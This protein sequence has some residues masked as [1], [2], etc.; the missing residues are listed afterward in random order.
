MLFKQEILD[1]I[2]TGEITLAFRRWRRPT[3]KSGGRLRTAIG[4]LAIER[5]SK[6]EADAIADSEARRAGFPDRATL[7]AELAR[8]EGEVFR[9][10]LRFAGAD[11]RIALRKNDRIGEAELALIVGKLEKM[12]SGRQGKWVLEALRLIENHPARRASD[13]AAMCGMDTP[14]FKRKVR[15]LKELGLTESL[16][17][18]YRLSPRGEHVLSHLSQ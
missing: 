9:I 12:D 7:L 3:V 14:G 4:E 15:Q 5:V 16:E 1:R 13:L 6:I 11:R 8:R 18:G 17:T 10:E 2:R